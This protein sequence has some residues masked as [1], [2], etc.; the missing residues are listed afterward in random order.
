MDQA[1]LRLRD[2]PVCLL[3]AG[4]KSMCY[5]ARSRLALRAMVTLRREEVL[6]NV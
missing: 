2:S 3:G 1:K 6:L 5:Q 4:T